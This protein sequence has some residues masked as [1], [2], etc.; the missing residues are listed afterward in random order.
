LRDDWSQVE[1]VFEVHREG[2]MAVPGVLGTAIGNLGGVPCILIYVADASVAD[3]ANLPG[4]L[5]GVAVKIEVTGPF[6]AR[7]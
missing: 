2:L 3:R 4:T 1:R 6:D 5:D 7:S